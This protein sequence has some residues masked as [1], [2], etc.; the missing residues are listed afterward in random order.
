MLAFSLL[1][2]TASAAPY[3]AYADAVKAAMQEN[4]TDAPGYGMLTDLDGDGTDELLL[5]YRSA[6]ERANVV[7]SV[8]TMKG[9]IVE[10]LLNL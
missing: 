10:T 8:Y 3:S 6:D 1:T 4:G 5:L 9:G 7:L 2:L